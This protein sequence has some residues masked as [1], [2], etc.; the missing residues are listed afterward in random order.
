M[1]LKLSWKQTQEHNNN[2]K[3]KTYIHTYNLLFKHD[4]CKQSN[5]WWRQLSTNHNYILNSLYDNSWFM[6]AWEQRAEST[7][8]QSGHK[9]NKTIKSLFQSQTHHLPPVPPHPAAYSRTPRPS[10]M[11]QYPQSM[12]KLKLDISSLLWTPLGSKTVSSRAL[13][14][15]PESSGNELWLAHLSGK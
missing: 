6:A 5:R 8:Y 10:L 9:K 7:L 15:W 13:P 2:T 1:H 14:H 4:L 12:S 3:L 11:T